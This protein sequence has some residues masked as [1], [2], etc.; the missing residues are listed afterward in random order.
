[1]TVVKILLDHPIADWAYRIAL[2]RLSGRAKAC[3]VNARNHLV[4]AQKI[5]D[6]EISTTIA[7]FCA[8]HATEEAVAC[9]IAA[10]KANCYKAW[11][12]KVN[13]RDHAHKAVVASYAQIIAGY[14]E[15]MR[16]SIAYNPGTDDVLMK[17][18]LD[19]GEVLYPLS[20]PI[21]SFNED[22]LNQSPEGARA[23]FLDRFPDVPTMVKH[24]HKRASFRDNALYAGDGGGPAL[25]REQ[26][27]VALREHTLLTFGLIWAAMD[28][29]KH[30][31]PE[32]FV[33]QV[34]GAISAVIAEVRPPKT[35]KVCGN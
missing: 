21:F 4:R 7:Y 29:M 12:S 34:L 32:P 25:S 33:I 28:V 23:A 35:C 5:T 14:A 1:M 22:G 8:T 20:L 11:A 2:E 10:A 16:L 13:V 18:I 19:E 3:A 31:Q 17:V 26:L 9:F 15:D 24:V 6:A 27:D 30:Q